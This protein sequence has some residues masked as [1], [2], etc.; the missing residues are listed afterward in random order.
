VLDTL[1]D[2]EVASSVLGEA[3]LH[4]AEDGT[5]TGSTGCRA[6]TGTWQS[7]GDVLAFP[8]LTNEDVACPPDLADQDAHVLDVLGN[9]PQVAITGDRLTLTAGDGRGLSYRAT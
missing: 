3:T 6:W 8:S 7:A 1:V 4:L 9:G 5:A 2:G